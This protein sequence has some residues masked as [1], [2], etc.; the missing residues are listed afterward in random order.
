MN[1]LTWPRTSPASSASP[2][3]ASIKRS[4]SEI[5]GFSVRAAACSY[6][7]SVISDSFGSSSCSSVVRHAWIGLRVRQICQEIHENKDCRQKEDGSLDRRK[8]TACDRVHHI[9]P[10]PRPGEHGLGENRA[11][12]IR[13]EI[14]TQH[15]DDR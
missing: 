1:F 10:D 5:F 4:L 15:G 2:A 3:A 14:E 13:A 7:S 9:S 8:I 6:S 11:G 12:E